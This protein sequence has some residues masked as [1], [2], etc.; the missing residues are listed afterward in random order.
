MIIKEAQIGNEIMRIMQDQEPE[1]P[2]DWDN[3]GTMVCFHTRY[4]LGDKHDFKAPCEF[5]QWLRENKTVAINLFL[6]DH[7]GLTISYTNTRY[8]FNSRWD[9]MQI[10][11]IYVTYETIRKEFKRKLITNKLIRKIQQILIREIETYDKYLRGDIYGYTI[12]KLETCETCK[13]TT[14][15]PIDTCFGFYSSDFEKNGLFES[16]GKQWIKAKWLDK[17]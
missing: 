9:A 15:T 6:Y 13:H 7:S 17:I 4:T 8:P 14:E 3:L 11:Y 1:S 12:V 2:R 5:M 16:A 10:G